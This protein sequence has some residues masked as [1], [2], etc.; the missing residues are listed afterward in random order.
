[1]AVFSRANV[2]LLYF[3]LATVGSH[4]SSSVAPRFSE[5]TSQLKHIDDLTRQGAFSGAREELKDLLKKYPQDIEVCLSAARFY[6]TIGLPSLAL[7]E[8]KRAIALG[9]QSSEPFVAVAQ[10]SLANLDDKQ[11][12][13]YARKAIAIDPTSKQAQVVLVSALLNEGELE[14]A[15]QKL[16]NVLAG[17]KAASDPDLNYLAYKLTSKRRQLALAKQCLD[18]A[19]KLKPDQTKWLLDRADLYISLGKESRDPVQKMED[20]RAAKRALERFLDLEPRSVEGLNR[21]GKLLEFYFYDFDKASKQYEK[22]LAI[23]PD[24]IA[25]ITGL[26]RC[27]ANQNDIAGQMKLEFWNTL[28]QLKDGLFSPSHG[29]Q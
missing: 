2:A 29:Q 6:K 4:A 9:C 21:Y 7:Q 3:C 22:I 24:Y 8:N 27:K 20:Y 5:R 15:G 25:A 13:E 26:A 16:A 10:I 18:N 28:R 23:D 12:L 14:E 11:A 17:G 19:I 1:M